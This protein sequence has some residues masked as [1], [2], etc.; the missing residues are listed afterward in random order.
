M[1][2]EGIYEPLKVLAAEEAG[3]T[4]IRNVVTK[5]LGGKFIWTNGFLNLSPYAGFEIP[6]QAFLPPCLP[7]NLFAGAGY[8]LYVGRL[9]ISPSPEIAL[10]TN[11]EIREDGSIGVQITHL[12]LKAL[13]Q[14]SI[15]IVDELEVAVELGTGFM[16]ALNETGEIFNSYKGFIFSIGAT[17]RF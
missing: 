17:G 12:G 9:T 15:L 11:L 5:L 14:A 4:Y 2:G 6:V 3:N 7:A 8:N 1:F 16:R 10:G 13:V